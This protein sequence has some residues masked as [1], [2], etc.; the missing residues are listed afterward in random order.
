MKN[1]VS[2][3]WFLLLGL[4]LGLLAPL[5]FSADLARLPDL[6]SVA[7]DLQ[8]PPTNPG[9]PAAGARVTQSTP[10]WEHTTVHHTLYLPTDW[11][12]GGK[13]PVLV[14]YPGNGNYRNSFG[15][16]STGKVE[17][18]RLGYGI[19]GGRGCIWICLPFVEIAG[20]HKQNTVT[21]WGDVDE[22]K[23]YCMATVRDVC[24]RYG[25]DAQRVVLCGFS[26]G[27]IA[28]NFIGLHDDEIAPLWRGFICHSHYDGVRETWPY[29]GADR[30]SALGRLRRLANRPQFISHEGSTGPTERYLKDTGVKGD[31]T[32]EP[33][34]FRNH[35][36][37]WVLR[38]IPSRQ[39]VRAWLQRI[40]K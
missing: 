16:V 19:T 17:D 39:R 18:C 33:I 12:A 5:A 15:D 34:P 37:Q 14:E 31:W 28:C 7:P 27:A 1:S 32:F 22:T 24:N 29:S 9:S 13:F 25:G 20:A 4:S 35:S 11:R 8:V 36:D 30:S 23:R 21:W 38:D 26:R 2:P 6:G 10:G 40:L 3:V